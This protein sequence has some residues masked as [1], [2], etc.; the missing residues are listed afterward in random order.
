MNRLISFLLLWCSVSF[1]G[2]LPEPQ[3]VEY[4]PVIRLQPERIRVTA[5]DVPAAVF[6]RSEAGSCIE[7]RDGEFRKLYT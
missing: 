2:I 1:A 5:P 4:G 3:S 7:M 6:W